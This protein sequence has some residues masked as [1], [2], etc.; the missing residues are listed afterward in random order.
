MDGTML[1]VSPSFVGVFSFARY[2]MSSSFTYTLTKLRSLPSS[3][4]RCLRKSANSFVRWPSASPT[5]AAWNSA[6]A[7]FPAYG[8]S[9]VGIITFTGISFHRCSLAGALNRSAVANFDAFGRK[10]L[11]II[12]QS[13][14]CHLLRRPVLHAHDNVAV[15]R[16]SMISI[17]LA[18]PCRMIR[19]RM[20]PAHDVEP[21]RACLFFRSHDVF[22]SYRKTITRRIVAAIDQRVQ[23]QNFALLRNGIFRWIAFNSRAGIASEQCSAA[24]MRISFR[25]MRADFLRELPADPKCRLVRHFYSSSQKRSFKYFAAESAKTV[26]ITAFLFF[27]RHAAIAKQPSSAAAALGLTSK[28]SS[29]ARRFTSWYASS[30]ET[31]KFSSAS[32]SS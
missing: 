13:P 9:G 20:I 15:P 11:P 21:M 5:V 1:I 4:K 31:V 14:G 2:R 23:R 24:L 22:R 18:G 29:L 27:G 3:V 19:M 25:A 26:T 6:E 30:V 8:R 17:E 28:P 16:P 7:R 12:I 10:L 32:L